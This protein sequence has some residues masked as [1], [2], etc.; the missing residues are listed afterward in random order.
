MGDESAKDK[1]SGIVPSDSQA[2]AKSSASLMGRGL[3][4]LSG[5]DATRLIEIAKKL[6][7]AY[8]EDQIFTI[9]DETIEEFLH[10]PKW[11]MVLTDEK[12]GDLRC[13]IEARMEEDYLHDYRIKIGD[14]LIR[15]VM[16]GIGGKQCI[17]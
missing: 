16:S 14:G 9:I 13:V 1:L 11:R 10:P 4:T 17:S 3:R 2:I 7:S 15:Y 12:Q 6:I 5:W 8:D